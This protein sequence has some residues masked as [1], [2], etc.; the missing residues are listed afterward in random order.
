[1]YEKPTANFILND[2]NL[3]PFPLILGMRQGYPLLPFLFKTVIE[4]L[5]REIKHKKKLPNRKGIN[6]IFCL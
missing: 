1:M 4:V 3:S 2:E 6:K 5:S